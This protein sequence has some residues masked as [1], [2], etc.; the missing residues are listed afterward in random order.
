VHVKAE[1]VAVE[2]KGSRAQGLWPREPFGRWGETFGDDTVAAAMIDRLVHHAKSSTS[3]ATAT[4]SRPRPREGAQRRHTVT[5][6]DQQ[7]GQFSPVA[8]GSDFTRC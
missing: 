1:Q 3:R 6:P 2:L 5:R 4:G 7:R 8:K